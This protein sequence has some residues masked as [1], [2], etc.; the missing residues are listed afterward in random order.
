MKIL[1]KIGAAFLTIGLV[2]GVIGSLNGGLKPTEIVAGRPRIIRNHDKVYQLDEFRSINIDTK[3]LDV[4][5]VD[6]SRYEVKVISNRT[7]SGVHVTEKNGELTVQQTSRHDFGNFG[8]AL[9]AHRESKIVITVPTVDKELTEINYQSN[10]A[11]L[12]LDG[13]KVRQIDFAA[14]NSDLDLLDT[15]VSGSVKVQMNNGDLDVQNSRLNAATLALRNGSLKLVDGEVH[16][17]GAELNN[18]DFEAH[19]T[20]FTGKNKISN[21]N[22]DNELSGADKTLGY[23]LRNK[24]GDNM[25]F[26]AESGQIMS[27]KWTGENQ[28]ELVTYNGDN[29]VE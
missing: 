17:L 10:N 2:M 16:N 26:G 23:R 15:E 29:T 11:D 13:L 1:A 4:D 7:N 18:G 28:I 20:K 12:F 14:A 3:N 22:G 8:F 25:L 19:A 9:A 6:G 5:I 24:Y 27:H 21:Q